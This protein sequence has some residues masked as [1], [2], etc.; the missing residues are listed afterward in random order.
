MSR[1]NKRQKTYHKNLDP[2]EF[3]DH[4]IKNLIRLGFKYN[5]FENNDFFKKLFKLIPVL[6]EL[7]LM[8]GMENIK[9]KI[10]EHTIFFL[11]GYQNNDM[12]HTV[13][14]G[15]PGC[16]KTEVSKILA[17]IYR[18]LGFLSTDKIDFVKSSDLIAQYLGQTGIKTLKRLE[19][20]KGGVMVI[21]EVYSL[22]SGNS[23]HD[24]YAKEALDTI[25]Q[26]LT[27]NKEDFV[28][29]IIGYEADINRCIFSLNQGLDRRFKFRFKIGEYTNNNLIDIFKYQLKRSEWMLEPDIDLD[30]LLGVCK[31]GNFGGDTENL[32]FY[33]KQAHSLSLFG[34]NNIDDKIKY[35]LTE[36]AIVKGIDE[37]NKSNENKKDNNNEP[38]FGLYI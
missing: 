33:I 15:A 6:I 25:N 26:F 11:Q 19:K 2:S 27:E 16:G 32:F 24:T 1:S 13:I 5:E 10:V 22:A 8:I 3:E 9:K 20:C 37:Y 7:D 28:M 36:N 29:I 14:M 30:K 4:S 18:E 12:L 38:P 34:L 35:T 17:R 21:D 31:F 23:G